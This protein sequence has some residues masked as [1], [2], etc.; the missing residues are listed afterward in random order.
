MKLSVLYM[1]KWVPRAIN[2]RDNNAELKC[3]ASLSFK[4]LD[5]DALFYDV[6][7]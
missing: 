1:V 7:V 6:V 5:R 2:I 4:K 3:G